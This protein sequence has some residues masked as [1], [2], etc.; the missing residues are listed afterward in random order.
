MCLRFDA[1]SLYATA[2]VYVEI[3]NVFSAMFKSKSSSIELAQQA[4]ATYREILIK[5]GRLSPDGP[6]GSA[7]G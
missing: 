3:G 6:F 5:K 2:S 7:Q 4:L 1:C